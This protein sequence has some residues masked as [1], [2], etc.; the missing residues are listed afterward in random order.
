[1]GLALRLA[2]RNVGRVPRRT[3]LT[4]AA[5]AFAVLLIVFFVAMAAGVHEKMIEDAVRVGSGHVTIVGEG[6]LENRTLEQFLVFDGQLR[7][8]LEESPGVLGYAPRLLG[9]GLLSKGSS[10]KGA[11][12]V[13]VDPVLEG[14]VSTLSR[15]V[16]HGRFLGASGERR[17]IV[18]AE[19]LAREL[20]AGVGDEVLLFSVAYSLEMAY[21][22]FRVVGILRLPEP[23]ADRSTAFVRLADAQEFFVYG[24]RVN[25]VAI[26]TRDAESAPRVASSLREALRGRAVEVHTWNEVMPEV[27]QFVLLD[28]IGMYMLLVILVVVVAFGILDTVL[29]AVL[30]RRREF[31]ILLAVGL[32]PRRLFALVFFESLVLG[33]LGLA[34]GLA[35]GIAL[36]LYFVAHPVALGGAAAGAVELWGFEPV[37]VW[38]LKP[39]NPLGSALTVFAVATLAALYPAWRAARS[40]PVEALREP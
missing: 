25:E 30:E 18:L 3:A 11:A 19:R 24:D 5:T 35:A 20:G 6:Y 22:L 2:W 23:E 38:K 31:G 1:M 21:E 16:R 36:V 7:R 10:T 28:D 9:F 27:E 32:L 17:E 37:L 33:G 40:E 34:V 14:N 29:M 26:L 39:W 13:G 4:V 8:V 12:V 15:R